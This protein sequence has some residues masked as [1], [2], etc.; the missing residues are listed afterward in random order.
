MSEHAAGFTTFIPWMYW[1]QAH[2]GTNV[3]ELI[4]L[5]HE[6]RRWEFDYEFSAPLFRR[7]E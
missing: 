7:F 3:P 6:C 4:Y 5:G 1:I 2:R